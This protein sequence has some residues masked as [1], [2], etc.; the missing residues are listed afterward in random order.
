MCQGEANLCLLY[1]ITAPFYEANIPFLM[2]NQQIRKKVEKLMEEER[3]VEKNRNRNS[4]TEVAKR[5][6]H[7]ENLDRTFL[8]PPGSYGGHQEGQEGLDSRHHQGPQEEGHEQG[9]RQDKA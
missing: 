1:Y 9:A 8:I 2:N 6:A 5:N 7:Q 3:K 4:A